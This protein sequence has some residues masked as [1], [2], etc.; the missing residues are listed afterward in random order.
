MAGEDSRDRCVTHGNNRGTSLWQTMPAV[1][2]LVPMDG[3]DRHCKAAA[4][5]KGRS[6]G[7]RSAWLHRAPA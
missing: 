7:S 5:G 6:Q 1:E 2:S 3:G 4:A